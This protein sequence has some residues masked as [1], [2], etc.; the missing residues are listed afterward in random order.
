[1]VHQNQEAGQDTQAK[2]VDALNNAYA[3]AEENFNNKKENGYKLSSEFKK[4]IEKLS[5]LSGKASTG[6]T[7]IVTCLAK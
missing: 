7:N 4:C 1:M 3:T 5:E 2:I 6:F